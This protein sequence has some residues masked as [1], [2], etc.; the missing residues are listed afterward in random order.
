MKV[1]TWSYELSMRPPHTPAS[2]NPHSISSVLSPHPLSPPSGGERFRLVPGLPA[3]GGHPLGGGPPAGPGQGRVFRRVAPRLQLRPRVPARVVPGDLLRGDQRARAERPRRPQGL[4]LRIRP[5]ESQGTGDCL[6][7]G[8][9][10][11][12]AWE[13]PSRGPGFLAQMSVHFVMLT[14]Q[15]GFCALDAYLGGRS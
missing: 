14:L 11:G 15:V 7:G 10:D 5:G 3:H 9:S 4:H 12:H 6:T 1:K 13:W 8:E 2:L